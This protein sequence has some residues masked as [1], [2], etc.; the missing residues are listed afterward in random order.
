MTTEASSLDVKE[1][2]FSGRRNITDQGFGVSVL[3][4]RQLINVIKS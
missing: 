4:L 2:G 3:E 1:V